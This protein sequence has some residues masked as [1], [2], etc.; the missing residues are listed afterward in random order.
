MYR[1]FFICLLT[2]F[3][4]CSS[5]K[6]EGEKRTVFRYNE[7]KGITSLDPAYAKDN[8]VI[9]PVNQIYNGLVEMDDSLHI[10]PSLAKKFEISMDCK[11]YTFHLRTDVCFH[12]HP[13]FKN[14]VGRHVTAYD[15]VYSFLRIIDPKVASP[16]F[17]LFK[18][19]EKPYDG[20]G[21]KVLNDSVFQIK[22][23]RP[24]ASFLGL[25]AMPYCFVLPREVV[26]FYGADFRSHPVGTGPFMLKTWREGEKLVLVKNP[27]Y[28]EIDAS[29]N[30]LPYLDAVAVTFISD[31]QSEF[32]EF[33]KGNLDFLSGVNAAYKD[34]MITRAGQLN[35]KY[36]NR[37]RM[38][39]LP[40]LN[41]EYLAFMLDS[42][43][44]GDKIILSKD[45]RTAINYGFDR[46]KMVKYLRNN[47]CTPAYWGIIPVGLPGF[48]EEGI[49]Y[50]YDPDK[51]RN[52]LTK[53]GYPNGRGLPE[54]KLTT[55]S[56]YLDI[57]EFIQH[58]LSQ[59][60]IKI[61]IE[62]SPLASFKQ[63]KASGNLSFFRSSWIADYPD[64]ENYLSLFFS[65]NFS[66]NGS[67][68]SH[69]KNNTYDEMYLKAIVE[70]D[71]QKRMILY[72]KLNS[73]I[74]DQAVIIP[75][76]YDRVVRLYPLNIHNFKGNPLNL[77][78][79]KEVIVTKPLSQ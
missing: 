29:G 10:K 62:V 33:M 19:V 39:V 61:S 22:L 73:I 3:I 78:K 47:L 21:F 7:S 6:R 35:P 67:N 50:T 2:F 26:E 8:T 15:F 45:F 63:N 79:L 16:G 17:S 69:F 55:T 25:L 24:F 28:F 57:C 36:R 18:M 34:E 11:T 4:S 37:F 44:T 12:N 76:F 56:D 1:A 60:G 70:P 52:Y 64:A 75:L 65:Q 71:L 43:K 51:A 20:V 53:A 5:Q 58:E 46:A 27:Q 66:P 41:T 9:W 59:I 42:T 13:K 32:L 74:V 31:K 54:I 23:Q 40:Y 49:H 30:R 77:L 68:Y 48:S 38:E 14:S 72:E